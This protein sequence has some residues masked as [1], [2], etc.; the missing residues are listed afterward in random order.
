M[1]DSP[2]S[3]SILMPVRNAEPF[4][5]SCL[6]SIRSQSW[7]DWE[8]LAVDDH[9]TDA[10]WAILHSFARRDLRI[11]PLKNPGK[12]IIP[13]LRHAFFFARGELVT[14]MDADDR[15]AAHKLATMANSLLQKGRGYVVAGQVAYFSD[16]ELGE[17]YRKYAAW[18]NEVVADNSWQSNLYR[19]CVL[20]SPCWM[21]FRED[22]AWSGAFE[23]CR[24]PEDYDLCFRMLSAGLRFAGIPKVLHF[25]RDH[26]D[27]SSRIQEVYRENS[28]FELKVDWFLRVDR[29]FSRPLC[30][31]G[32]GKR[33]KEVARLLLERG[34]IFQW[35]T[36]NPKKQGKKIY[37]VPVE[38]FRRVKGI[39]QAQW[40]LVISRDDER[41]Q[42]RNRLTQMG[43]LPSDQFS[44]R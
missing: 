14:R 13:A 1:P 8:L 6:E 10:S 2:V 44:F 7:Q 24:Y 37:R 9:S 18:L 21:T 26:Q 16:Q 32:A 31:W 42:V 3:V 27:R 25:W 35:I 30:L 29:D 22:L 15:M 11:Q 43:V 28:F 36:D 4:L 12:G 5:A 23:G 41:E 20:P 34:A 19:E 33:G 40:C 39:Q 38:A 17:G